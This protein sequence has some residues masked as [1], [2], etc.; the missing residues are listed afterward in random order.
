MPIRSF[1][2]M[3][4]AATMIMIGKIRKNKQGDVW[5]EGPGDVPCPE[6]CR[7]DKQFIA[8]NKTA[9]YSI[10][11]AKAERVVVT[12]MLM[13]PEPV[14]SYQQVLL[15]GTPFRSQPLPTQCARD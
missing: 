13:R 1:P 7:N 2:S 11:P 15:T 4:E 8:L 10:L 9:K 12:Y 6:V 14:A 5:Q 3:W